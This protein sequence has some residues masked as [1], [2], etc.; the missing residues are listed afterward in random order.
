ML[1]PATLPFRR[2]RLRRFVFDMLP[3]I[4]AFRLLFA[5]PYATLSL[6][7]LRRCFR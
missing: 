5:M 6:L 7:L 3:L 4:A 1:L 2:Y